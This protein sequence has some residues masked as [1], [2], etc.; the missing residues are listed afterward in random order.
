[1][2]TRPVL[3]TGRKK[4]NRAPLVVLAA[5]LILVAV[6]IGLELWFMERYI[7]VYVDGTSMASTLR[8]GD[9]LYADG[10]A[11]PQR[12]DI[13]IIDVS[14][15]T[16]EFGR[17]LFRQGSEPIGVIV[18]RLIAREGDAVRY[19]NGLIHIRYAGTD[20]F[21]YLEEDYASGICGYFEETEL[22]EGEIFVLGDNRLISYDSSEVGALKESDI[23]GVV[24]QWSVRIKSFTT[25]WERFRERINSLFGNRSH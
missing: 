15:Y 13:I 10:N 11:Q 8:S 14:D 22:K 2:I 25:G 17:P 16:D 12:G 1:M 4:E 21:V 5:L 7:P 20:D 18:K 23:I 6:L 9:W 3:L 24:P 19:E